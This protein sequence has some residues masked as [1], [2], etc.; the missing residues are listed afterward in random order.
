M[1]RDKVRDSLNILENCNL[2]LREK[3]HGR[4]NNYTVMPEGVWKSKEIVDKSK[5]W[6]VERSTSG[7]WSG[8]V[9]DRGAVPNNTNLNKTKLITGTGFLEIVENMKEINKKNKGKH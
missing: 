3:S 4:K 5:K 7:P 9:V 6:T 8:L 1:S 2:I